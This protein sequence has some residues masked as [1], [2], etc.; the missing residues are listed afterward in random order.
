MTKLPP[1]VDFLTDKDLSLEILLDNICQQLQLDP[2][3]EKLMKKA[4][5]TVSSIIDADKSFFG[6]LDPSIYVYGSKAIGTTTKPI[7]RDEFDLDFVIKV[8]CDWSRISVD[9][10]L[11]KLYNLLNSDGRYKGKVEQLRFCVRIN[12]KSDFHMDIMPGCELPDKKEKLRIPDTKLRMWP[13]RNPKGYISWFESKYLL[14]N[15]LIK[16]HDYYK[17]LNEID[18]KAEVED[19]PTTLN[20]LSIQPLQRAVQLIKRYRDIYFENDKDHATSSVILTTIAGMFYEGEQSIVDTIDGI[21]NRVSNLIDQTG[22]SQ[23]IEIINPADIRE[24]ENDKERFSDKWKEGEKGKR[25]YKAFVEFIKDFHSNWV[26]LR[27]TETKPHHIIGA[28][29]G[30]TVTEESFENQVRLVGNWRKKDSLFAGS[31]GVL[32]MHS[33]SAKK[34]PKTTIHGTHSKG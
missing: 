22:V 7:G 30:E 12:Y 11:E 4:Y 31:T 20:Y 1:N 17:H 5:E 18:A 13:I 19:M 32:S 8:S 9:D 28:L 14:D 33:E 25:R 24:N 21:L 27:R 16:L 26:K 34:I 29:F 3:R 2:T 23:P 10:F 6:L 15:S